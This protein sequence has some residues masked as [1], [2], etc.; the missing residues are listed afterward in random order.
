MTDNS[1]ICGES[2]GKRN[3]TL[4]CKESAMSWLSLTLKFDGITTSISTKKRAPK[5]Y[6][7]MTSTR[8]RS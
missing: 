8:S 2:H 1:L 6:A 3:F 5:Q 7:R 4:C